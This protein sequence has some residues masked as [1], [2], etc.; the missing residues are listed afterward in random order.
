MLIPIAFD[1]DNLIMM[2]KWIETAP[3]SKFKWTYINAERTL[4]I[5]RHGEALYTE[6]N[7]DTGAR[8]TRTL[9][10]MVIECGNVHKAMLPYLRKTRIRLLDEHRVLIRRFRVPP[11]TLPFTYIEN[12]KSIGK[13]LTRQV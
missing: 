2:I 1:R 13:E 11:K 3:S 6:L 12:I 9:T 5:Y 10:D 7:L 8:I 4:Y